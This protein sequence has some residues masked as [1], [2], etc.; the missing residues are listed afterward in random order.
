MLKVFSRLGTPVHPIRC[1]PVVVVFHGEE[2]I[3][4]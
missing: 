4:L 3:W 2:G 1:L